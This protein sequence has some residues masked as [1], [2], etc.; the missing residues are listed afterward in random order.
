MAAH[1]EE[2]GAIL[3]R[4][5]QMEAELQEVGWPPAPPPP[6]PCCLLVVHR[7]MCT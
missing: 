4:M 3:A 5:Q 7:L 1:A 2:K 6:P